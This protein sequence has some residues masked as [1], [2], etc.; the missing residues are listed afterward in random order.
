[1]HSISKHGFSVYGL[2]LDTS[3]LILAELIE[4]NLKTVKSIFINKNTEK[5]NLA[6]KSKANYRLQLLCNLC[7]LRLLL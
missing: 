2:F 1:M 3:N 4:N 6:N 5:K 7:S